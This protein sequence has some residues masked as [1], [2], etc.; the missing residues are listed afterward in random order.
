MGP[1]RSPKMGSFF[2]S[3]NRNKRSI[4]ADLK[5][6]EGR[7]I[8][9]A[10]LGQTDVLLHSMRSSAAERLGLGYEALAAQHPR[11]IYCHV[12]YTCTHLSP[13]LV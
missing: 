12:A 11:L 13:Q 6:P 3:N 4:V 1:K 9:H 5:T 8:L 7:E 2:L 10:L